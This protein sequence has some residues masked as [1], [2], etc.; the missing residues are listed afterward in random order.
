MTI[1]D[2]D[3]KLNLYWVEEHKQAS[4]NIEVQ[5]LELIKI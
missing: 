1:S 3:I 4:S 5:E 2:L